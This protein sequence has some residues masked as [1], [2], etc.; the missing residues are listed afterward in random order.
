MTK[1]LLKNT[2]DKGGEVSP[3]AA[4]SSSSPSAPPAGFSAPP[5]EELPTGWRIVSVND[6]A[7][8]TTIGPFG[9]RMKSETYTKSGVPVIR[10]TNLSNGK[11]LSGDWVYISEE[12]A[13]ELSNCVVTKEDLVFPH[14]GS[15][16]EVGV[17]PPNPDRYV[18]SS[19]LMMLRCD[20]TKALSDY[21][22]Y[23]FKSS[24]GKFEL[25]KNASQVG[26]PGIGQPLS[27]L[28]DIEISLPPLS[29]QY[30]IS[31]ILSS[32]DAKMELNRTTNQTLEEIAKALFKSWFVDFDPVYAKTR[33]E[34]PVGMDDATAALF[35]DNLVE[36]ELGLIPQGWEI[37]PITQLLLFN[38]ATKMAKKNARYI[39]MKNIPIAGPAVIDM[40]YREFTSGSKFVNGDT[41]FARITPCTENGKT[42]YINTLEINEVAW[43]ST[44]FIVIRPQSTIPSEIG[45]FFARDE[46]FRAFAIANMTGS[47]GRQRVPV[48]IFEKYLV[49]IPP[50]EIYTAFGRIAHQTINLIT[51]KDQEIKVLANIRDTLIP[52][53]MSGKISVRNIPSNY[54]GV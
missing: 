13:D 19:S 54:Q 34:H 18:I 23:F 5:H 26:T 42:A 12:F 16:G 7:Q 51:Q 31:Q 20:K 52:K 46:S 48:N 4:N 1:N 32:L 10:G 11:L 30:K 40:T 27:S 38:P 2:I 25:L 41:I 47:S 50:I 8:K 39:D 29:E 22:Y 49:V 45:Y 21:L 53:L 9:S 24:K 33:G 43:G 28:R 14:R 44:E 3:L 17:V 37:K 35:P 15:I 36:S 6:I